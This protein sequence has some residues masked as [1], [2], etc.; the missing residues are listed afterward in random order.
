M[1]DDAQVA[2]QLPL[3]VIEGARSGRSRCKVCRRAINKDILR[4]GVLI[5]GP[6]G[7][8]YLWHHLTCA[9]R[10]KFESVEE[11]YEL[12]A[13]NEAKTPPGDVPSLD[14][15]R[16]I[17]EDAEDRKRSRKPIP[18]AELAPSGRSKCKHC[19]QTIEK[20][21]VRV[22]LGRGV[23]FGSQVRTSPINVHPH[24]VASEL[25][26]EDCATEAEGFEAALR[27]NSADLP[28]ERLDR[29]MVEIGDL[30]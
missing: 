24:C 13:W 7:T 28:A 5:E 2:Q 25:R 17:R 4:L 18:H 29:L 27:E 16:K 22:V 14:E 6:Y 11:A 19:D 3:Y 30:S 21:S 10:R 9:A 1:S 26:A 20:D 23:Y 12:Q 8:G 15:L